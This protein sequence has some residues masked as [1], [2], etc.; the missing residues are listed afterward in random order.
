MQ[1]LYS[2][3]PCIYFSASSDG[4]ITEA[5]K[6][7]CKYLGYTRD[8]LIGRKLE[9]IFTLST[10]IFQQTHL[11]PLLQ[12]KG[13]A[14]EI[15]ITLRT[16]ENADVPVLINAERKEK[17]GQI[18]FQFAGIGLN[19][20][21]KF[22]EEIIAAKK[23]AEKALN[24]NT[25]LKT[26]QEELQKHA[27]ELDRQ[28]SLAHSQNQELKQLNHSFT[29]S[30][31]EPL[32]KFLFYSGL[33]LESKEE[34]QVISGVQKIK[35]A[36]EDMSAK[37]NGLQQYVWLTNEQM[38]FGEVDFSRIIQSVIKELEL[39]NEEI[40]IVLE[41]EP[42]P[43]IE[44]NNEQMQILMKE[45][46]SNAI[47]FRKSGKTVNVN[48]FA[49][50]LLLNNFRQLTGKYKYAEFVKLEVQ[51]NGVGFNDKYQDQAFELFRTL[52]P[53]GGLGIG[54]S[55][56]KK[57]VENHNGYISLES[58]KDIGSKVIMSFPLRRQK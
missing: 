2:D 17:D 5:N 19:K 18:H 42:I 39:E 30:L 32:R 3:I 31:Q 9:A 4:V 38:D 48:I 20:R 36:V 1:D 49:T 34:K 24:E 10:R 6:I 25:S 11:Y 58:Q 41:T 55:F 27:E 45:I 29:H 54:L 23:A 8:E 28:I 33:I 43:A 26:A 7:L 50:T 35:K 13:L 16:K 14:D 15:Y 57:I 51:D 46:L 22:E 12:L 52:H 56:C 53:L 37:I 40:S 44:A 47:R 21:Q